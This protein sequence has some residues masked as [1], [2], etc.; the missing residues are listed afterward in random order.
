VLTERTGVE[1]QG[2]HPAGS[3]LMIQGL[4]SERV[5]VLLDGQPFIGR[6]AGT[7]DVSRIPTSMI[8]RI[9]VVKGPQS[10][11]YGSEAMGGVVNVITR[12]PATAAWTASGSVTA[13]DQ[14][15]LD[16]A[17]QALGGVGDVTGVA[18]IGRRT[19]EL[20]PGVAGES[21][22]LATRWDG[23]GR[24]AW[25][26]PLPGLTLEA[27]GLLLDERQRWR[28]GQLYQFADNTQWTGR[29]GAVWE[30][31]PHRVTPTV[32]ATSFDHL[33]RGG[34]SPVPAEGSGERERQ[35][36]VEGELLYSLALGEHAVDAGFEV[37]HETIRS[38]RVADARRVSDRAESF[39][40]ATF[41]WGAFTLVPG[42]RATSSEPWGSHWTPRIAALYRP[43]PELGLRLAIGEGF[44]A[45]DFKELHMEF[46]NI[47]PGFA[48]TVRG[49]PDLFPEQSRNVTASVEWAGAQTYLRIQGFENRFDNFIETR[50]AGDSSGVQVFTYGNVDD[51]FTRGAELEAGVT[52][53]GLRAEASYAL[54]RAERA[55]TGEPLL[56]RPEMSG[57][58]V[59]GYVR[60][61]GLRLSLTGVYT[62]RT[63]MQHTENGTDWRAGFLRFDARLARRVWGGFE[64]AAG[65][66]N[67]LDRQP[68]A[69]PGFAGR[70]VYTT[71]SW[72]P[73]ADAR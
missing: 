27:A 59:L 33:S 17:G 65:V 43:L 8:E 14:G 49:N 40:Q 21:G 24:V 2:G 63:P 46:L 10:T 44:R 62:G 39:A 30:R 7:I 51:G 57:R 72:R 41:S 29:L 12:S 55:A 52:W 16:V 15:R 38:D 58:A 1:L 64:V 28:G 45:P 5:L 31:G 36:L 26:T 20:A 34:P 4:G 70:H 56:G 35:R 13:G 6:I 11:V 23:R 42:V 3:G 48:Y 69:W 61:S 67:L 50:P 19:I 66:D 53:G 71:L 18:D 9:E 60:P 47:G 22:A 54:L 32:F 68:D 73:A 25:R 37:R